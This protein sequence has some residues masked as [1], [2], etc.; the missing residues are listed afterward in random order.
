MPCF[1]SLFWKFKP[2]KKI[3]SLNMFKYIIYKLS[4]IWPFITK[5]LF[6]SVIK[7]WFY[8][9]TFVQLKEFTKSQFNSKFGI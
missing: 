4:L 9:I 2:V 6:L 1:K 3:L 5:L 7:M 8:L